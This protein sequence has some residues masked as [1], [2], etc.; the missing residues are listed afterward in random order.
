M[1]PTPSPP[2]PA[3]P[4]AFNQAVAEAYLAQELHKARRILRRTRITSLVLIAL[5]GTYMT[6]VSAMLTRFLQPREAAQVASGMMVQHIQNNGPALAVRL[7]REI[8]LLIRDTPVHLLQQLPACRQEIEK[9]L[10]LEFRGRCSTFANELGTEMDR[11]IESH[12]AD[13]GRLLE[14][15]EDRE[16]LRK[17][18]P[19]F[20]RAITGFLNTDSDGRLVKKQIAELAST[21]AQIDQRVDR[22]ANGSS[23][24]TEEQKARRALAMLARIIDNQTALPDTRQAALTRKTADR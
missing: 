14:N 13:I 7:E 16:A 24:T 1:G 9:S 12:K 23:L 4:Q 22:L 21:L 15:A 20:E 8:P 10:A 19:D 3:S 2:S 6:V 5:V 18:L 11:L 17:I